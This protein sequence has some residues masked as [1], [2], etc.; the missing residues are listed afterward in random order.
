MLTR[1]Q[2][3]LYLRQCSIEYLQR[4]LHRVVCLLQELKVMKVRRSGFGV[5]CFVAKL[6]RSDDSLPQDVLSDNITVQ[7]SFIL[8]S[9]QNIDTVITVH[10][11]LTS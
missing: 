8:E 6:N 4:I 11:F 2:K 3:L 10:S 5:I 7:Y 9:I 1:C